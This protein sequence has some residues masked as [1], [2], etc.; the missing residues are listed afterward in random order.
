MKEKFQ[1]WCAWHLPKWLVKWAAIRL[2][3]H[4]TSGEY[5]TTI[6]PELSAMDAIKRWDSA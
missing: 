1:I 5:D 3:A 6:V 4:A 2:V